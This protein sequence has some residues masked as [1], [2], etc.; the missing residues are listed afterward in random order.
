MAELA[1]DDRLRQGAGISI[2]ER[3][4]RA[5]IDLRG[6]VT[7]ARFVHAVESVTDLRPPSQG[8]AAASGLLASLLW[9]GPDEWLVVSETQASGELCARLR[10]ALRGVHAAVTEVGDARIVYA[11]A[12]P[13][14]RD[15]FAKGC[16]LDL[17]PRAFRP[18]Q[19]AQTLLGKVSVLIHQVGQ[20]PAY[21]VYVARS[22]ADYAWAWLVT[23]AGEYLDGSEGK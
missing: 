6:D 21:E 22:F 18:G 7:D 1:R 19:C 8:L 4:A 12:G 14:A 17:H 3:P 10:Q 15:V 20:D 16:P 9:L 13:N 2:A 11:V 23:A 5:C